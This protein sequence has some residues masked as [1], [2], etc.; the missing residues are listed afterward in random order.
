MQDTYSVEYRTAGSPSHAPYPYST[1][2]NSGGGISSDEYI[3]PPQDALQPLQSDFNTASFFSQSI[4]DS[5]VR[6]YF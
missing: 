1:D 2:L 6:C 4:A 5:E 3:Q